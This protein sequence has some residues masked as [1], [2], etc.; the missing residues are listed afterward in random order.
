M[1]DSDLYRE[2]C[3]MFRHY[4][5]ASLTIRIALIAQSII[6]LSGAGY[7][8]R[9]SEF[10]HAMIVGFFGLIF[11]FI[12]FFLHRS[13]QHKCDIFAETAILLEKT[14]DDNERQIMTFYYNDYEKK[15]KT[16]VGEIFIIDG[17][18]YLMMLT[19]VLLI[20]NVLLKI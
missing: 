9:L 14:I 20:V 12:L 17:F 15:I 11:T 13:Y 5:N 4:S 19:F 7:L 8:Y 18:F 3:I 10:Y 6:I 1:N 16:I 2:S